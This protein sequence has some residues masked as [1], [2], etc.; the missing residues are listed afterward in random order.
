MSGYTVKYSIDLINE[1]CEN[2]T[3]YRSLLRG[4]IND[5]ETHYKF[6]NVTKMWYDYVVFTLSKYL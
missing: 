2:P 1:I 6:G 4:A 3:K 5:A